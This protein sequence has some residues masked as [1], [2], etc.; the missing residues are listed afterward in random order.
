MNGVSGRDDRITLS[1]A[2][3]VFFVLLLALNVMRT[4]R[5]AMWR[6]ELQIHLLGSNSP[7]L[8]ELFRNLRY[9]A[10]GALWDALVWVLA[11]LGGGPVAMQ[12]LHAAIAATAWILVYR[13]SPFTRL[14]KLLLLL[15]YFLFFEYFVLS[16]SYG[17][18]ILL[19]FAFVAL[20]Q[21][22]PSWRAVP[23]LLLGLLANINAFVTIWSI[24]LAA[25]FVLEERLRDA[26][27]WGG[28]V[29]YLVLLSAGL[30]TMIP[31][32]D[33]GPWDASPKL[34]LASVDNALAITL[35][36]FV[37][38]DPDWFPAAAAFLADPRPAPVPFSWNPSPLR[39]VVA[40]TQADGEHLLRLA[41]ILLVPIILCALV[42]RQRYRVLEF[43]LAFLGMM[44][45]AVL[46]HY[47]GG[48]RHF[49]LVFAA[50]VASAW[51]ARARAPDPRPSGFL[52]VILAVSAFGGTLSLGSEF[53]TFS[54]ARNA[55]RWL[56]NENSANL[57]LIGQRDAQ[58]SS[59]AG[60]LGRPVYYL[61]CECIGTFIR[62]NS[63]RQSPLSEQQ[64]RE[65]LARALARIGRGDAILI[66][67]V[68]LDPAVTKNLVPGRAL[69]LAASFTGAT[70]DEN[71]WIYRV[72]SVD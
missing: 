15:S 64:F 51:I 2:A 43:S 40:I 67:N 71:Y 72:T 3:D 24:A 25:V 54:Q 9:E 22:R 56:Q 20:R 8:V 42:T 45:F 17:L 70:T 63:T 35:G 11:Q 60:Y 59:V 16:R 50:F 65:R 14:E 61:E 49:G 58:V 48:S 6:D 10:H 33:Y 5:H 13:Y 7:T 57:P 38:I 68:P 31:A 52:I 28:A 1:I 39:W 4:L 66:R 34:D 27:F 18:A 44:L 37:P 29:I 26:R 36:A 32:P 69:V 23:W 55:A 41:S 47:V 21:H 19:G 30:A 46:W 53:T 12:V 62:W